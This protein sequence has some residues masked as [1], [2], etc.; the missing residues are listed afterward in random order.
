VDEAKEAEQGQTAEW[1]G[2]E[3]P[4]RRFRSEEFSHRLDATCLLKKVGKCSKK[5]QRR[6]TLKIWRRK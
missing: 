1:R 5:L 6:Y 4:E 3:P 2:E